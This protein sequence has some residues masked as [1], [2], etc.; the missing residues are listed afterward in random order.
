MMLTLRCTFLLRAFLQLLT[1][2]RRPQDTPSRSSSPS[3]PRR[4]QHQSL[5]LVWVRLTISKVYQV[6]LSLTITMCHRTDFHQTVGRSVLKQAGTGKTGKPPAGAGKVAITPLNCLTAIA[7]F[8]TDAE[9]DHL[10]VPLRSPPSGTMAVLADRRFALGHAPGHRHA[11]PPAPGLRQRSTLTGYPLTAPPG[12]LRRLYFLVAAKELLIH[13]TCV[14][15]TTIT[16]TL[17][18]I[19]SAT[20]VTMGAVHIAGTYQRITMQVNITIPQGLHIMI[21]TIEDTKGI[22]MYLG[23]SPLVAGLRPMNTV[24]F[25]HNNP[26]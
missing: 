26:P 22:P 1:R 7:S 3:K 6:L 20:G 19:L 25:P 16:L 5:G 17:D 24:Q 4:T 23:L 11:L 14:T 15:V 13:A 2:L 18:M 9:I 8:V 21:T 10:R 12:G